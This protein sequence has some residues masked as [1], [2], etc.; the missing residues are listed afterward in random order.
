MTT[1]KRNN[2]KEQEEKLAELQWYTR[3]YP[4]IINTIL[5][6]SKKDT[7]PLQKKKRRRRNYAKAVKCITVSNLKDPT[8]K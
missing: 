5:V 3:I 7:D 8:I 2:L 1:G 4:L 6:I